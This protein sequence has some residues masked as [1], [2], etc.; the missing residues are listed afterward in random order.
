MPNQSPHPYHN[1]YTQPVFHRKLNNADYNPASDQHMVIKSHSRK[2]VNKT[3]GNRNHLIIRE[4]I[5]NYFFAR[6]EELL[7]Q[8]I[9]C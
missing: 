8:N 5:L 4:D 6:F 2:Y 1:T 9:S 7:A 3:T